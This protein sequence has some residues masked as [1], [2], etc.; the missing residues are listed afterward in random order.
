MPDDP[1]ATSWVA[2]WYPD[3]WAATGQ[4]FWNGLEWTGQRIVAAPPEA[5]ISEWRSRQWLRAALGVLVGF[6][7][8]FAFVALTI[9]R[10]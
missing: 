3:P 5:P 8:V 1:H 10:I 9:D 6:V 7:V 2:G 4:R